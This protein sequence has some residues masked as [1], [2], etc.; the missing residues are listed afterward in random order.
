MLWQPGT[1]RKLCASGP[2]IVP[3]AF[4][5]SSRLCFQA[6]LFWCPSDL[7]YVAFFLSAISVVVF[8]NGS[9][10]SPWALCVLCGPGSIRTLFCLCVWVIWLWLPMFLSYFLFEWLRVVLHI[11]SDSPVLEI[12]KVPMCLCDPW[13]CFSATHLPLMYSL[14]VKYWIPGTALFSQR[15]TLWW[16]TVLL[17]VISFR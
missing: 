7:L 13:S 11:Y 9:G 15:I 17:S 6:Y 4:D 5:L 1:C 10:L 2:H 12:Y 3:V 8:G 16:Q 14:S